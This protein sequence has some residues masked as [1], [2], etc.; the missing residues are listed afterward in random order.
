MT[1]LGTNIMESLDMM[2]HGIKGK[3]K[4]EKFAQGSRSIRF[5]SGWVALKITLIALF[6]GGIA[7]LI[8]G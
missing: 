5:K 2:R 4:T 3:S 6:Y 8:F 7:Y 1:E